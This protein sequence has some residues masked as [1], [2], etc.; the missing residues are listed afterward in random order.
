MHDRT[1][2]APK[3]K[4]KTSDF[5]H[6]TLEKVKNRQIVFDLRFILRL[7]DDGRKKD[8]ADH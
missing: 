5:N 1:D 8:G 4:K 2:D 6:Q 3:E 7:V